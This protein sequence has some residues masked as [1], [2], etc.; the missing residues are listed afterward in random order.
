[1]TLPFSVLGGPAA[2][3]RHYLVGPEKRLI[4]LMIN[5]LGTI[6]AVLDCR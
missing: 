3:F 5:V 6:L 2:R 4:S 1:M